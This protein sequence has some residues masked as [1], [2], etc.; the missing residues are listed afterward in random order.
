MI[1]SEKLRACLV[2]LQ[3]VGELNNELSKIVK[4]RQPKLTDQLMY[5]SN[6]ELLD[7]GLSLGLTYG[8]LVLPDQ[9]LEDGAKDKFMIQDWSVDLND[10]RITEALLQ[11]TYEVAKE[12]DIK[13]GR[14][15][16][17]LQ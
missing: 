13:Q 1:F 7:R 12:S 15:K 5:Q 17:L 10:A 11:T 4:G 16:P 3:S 8:L 14:K 6:V 2:S 9:T